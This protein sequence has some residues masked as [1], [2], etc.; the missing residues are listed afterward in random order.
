MI[1]FFLKF[2][3]SCCLDLSKS[4]ITLKFKVNLRKCNKISIYLCPYN[5]IRKK[6][7]KSDYFFI[8]SIYA[9]TPPLISPTLDSRDA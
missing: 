6:P 3:L 7:M 2:I 9:V 1:Y 5:K 4:Q 8:D